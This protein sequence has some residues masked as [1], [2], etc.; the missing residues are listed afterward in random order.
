MET[1]HYPTSYIET[2]GS[3]VTRSAETVTAKEVTRADDLVEITGDNF[4]SFYNFDEATVYHEIIDFHYDQNSRL[5][6]IDDNTLDNRIATQTNS[7]TSI[8][9]AAVTNTVTEASPSIAVSDWSAHQ[10]SPTGI[11]EQRRRCAS[12]GGACHS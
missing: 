1:K 5:L 6:S 2:R 9:I 7:E 4:K 10:Q 3:T 8:R 12:S 11:R